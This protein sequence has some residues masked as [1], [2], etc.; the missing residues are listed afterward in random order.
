MSSAGAWVTIITAVIAGLAGFAAL[1]KTFLERPKYRADAM[2]L[3]TQAATDQMKTLREDNVDVRK[4]LAEVEKRLDET[5]AKVRDTEDKLDT[6]EDALVSTR[7]QNE[8]LRQQ[9]RILVQHARAAAVWAERYYNAEHP[10]GMLPPPTVPN[11][12]PVD[13]THPISSEGAS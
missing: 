7:R 11:I 1:I 13:Q 8:L 6:T 12:D 10:A 3:V 2:T 5:L 9:N 4:R